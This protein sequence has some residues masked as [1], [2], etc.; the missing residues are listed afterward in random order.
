MRKIALLLCAVLLTGVGCANEPTKPEK[1]T[2]TAIKEN[3]NTAKENTKKETSEEKKSEDQPHETE[4]KKDVSTAVHLDAAFADKVAEK[5]MADGFVAETD[6]ENRRHKEQDD[7]W[8]TVRKFR[9]DLDRGVALV[10]I[11]T[12]AEPGKI[13][14]LEKKKEYQGGV[15]IETKNPED[16]VMFKNESRRF[17]MYT[18]Y[19][20]TTGYCIIYKV[21]GNLSEST[22]KDATGYGE[23]LLQGLM[24]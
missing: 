19:D 21:N 10:I 2:E 18:A 14:G 24:K 23:E 17:A 16:V 12:A 7:T 9:K 15:D 1:T 20:H 5:A 22:L 8:H 4:D 3:E 13:K 11:H 6:E